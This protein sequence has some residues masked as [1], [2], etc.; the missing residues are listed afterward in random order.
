MT[1][2][3][4]VTPQRDLLGEGPT[5]DARRR[6]LVHVDILGGSVH[7]YRPA[8][9]QTWSFA[10]GIETGAAVPRADGGFL[11]AV[12]HDLVAHEPNGDQRLVASVE[13][14]L[15]HTRFNDCRCDAVG[16]LWAGTMSRERLAAT[17]GL[18]RLAPGDDL[19]CVIAGT[20]LSNGIG[21]SPASDVMYFI[22]STTQRIDAFDYDLT[23]SQ[24]SDRRTFARID[25]RDG[26]PDG[27]TVDADGRVW[28]CLFGGGA[29]RCYG[30]DGTVEAHIPLPVS[31]PTCPAF[32]D[33]DLGTLYVTSSRHRLT[34]EQHAAEPLA[35]ALLRC[36]PGVRGQAGNAFSG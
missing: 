16:T 26:L 36:R 15:D 2:W 13:I 1:T 34:A 30:W 3:E 33:D 7:G 9:G 14:E 22:D 4:P 18:Y 32:G 11:L 27:L 19:R 28:V 17:A 23:S 21:W 5:W 25:P 29:I 10:S 8:S 35:G 12:N 31:C 6:E 24:L 20:T